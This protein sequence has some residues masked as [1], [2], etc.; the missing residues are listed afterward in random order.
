[1]SMQ[2]IP[3]KGQ[4]LCRLC[5]EPLVPRP[6]HITYLE[7]AFKVELAACPHCGLALV[8]ENLATGRMLEVEQIL[9]GK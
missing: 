8:P 5:N 7:G 2:F 6:V 9:E 3:E 1:M 4:W